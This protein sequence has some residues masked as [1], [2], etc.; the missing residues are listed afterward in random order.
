MMV[1]VDGELLNSV[2]DTTFAVCLNISTSRFQFNFK[3]ANVTTKTLLYPQ[4]KAAT[5]A[6][7]VLPKPTSSQLKAGFANFI[8]LTPSTW[9]G[10]SVLF[11]V[12]FSPSYFVGS[13]GTKEILFLKGSSQSSL[14]TK[15]LALL[16][17][18]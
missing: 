1:K 18:K 16:Y 4:S 15:K 3:L 14:Y 6:L 2:P 13:N 10:N 8:N 11:K 9:C 17:P 12:L 5:I 7:A